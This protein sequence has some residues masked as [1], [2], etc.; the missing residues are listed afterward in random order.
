MTGWSANQ[1]DDRSVD[2]GLTSNTKYVEEVGLQDVFF[3]VAFQMRNTMP[4]P[5]SASFLPHSMKV[6]PLCQPF[7][8]CWQHLDCVDLDEQVNT[9]TCLGIWK[10]FLLCLLPASRTCVTEQGGA[11]GAAGHL[12]AVS[13][14][15]QP[16]SSW[17]YQP[18]LFLP[19]NTFCY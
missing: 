10:S 9:N 19:R 3:W 14:A 15:V 4:F 8:I 1:R 6:K 2:K 12:A 5:A 18:V 7:I 16:S 17:S 11:G 13:I